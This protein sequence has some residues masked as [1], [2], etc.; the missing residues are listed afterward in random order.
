MGRRAAGNARIRSMTYIHGKPDQSQ[1][2]FRS[3]NETDPVFLAADTFVVGGDFD[4]GRESGPADYS[5]FNTSAVALARTRDISESVS[6]TTRN[7]NPA[8]I[9]VM[10]GLDWLLLAASRPLFGTY[11]LRISVDLAN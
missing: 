2:P 10:G 9:R 7:I 6:G 8:C 11:V 3:P 5:F 4:A 1:P